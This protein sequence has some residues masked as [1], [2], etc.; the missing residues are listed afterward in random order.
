MTEYDKLLSIEVYCVNCGKVFK[1][2]KRP[3]SSSKKSRKGIRFYNCITCSSKCSREWHKK[4]SSQ[5][6]SNQKEA[7]KC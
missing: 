2:N 7:K 3:N 5:I 1:R 6:T 4:S